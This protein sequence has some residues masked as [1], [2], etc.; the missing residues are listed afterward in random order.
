MPNFTGVEIN[1]P[2]RILIYFMSNYGCIKFCKKYHG[3]NELIEKGFQQLD[4][5]LDM[6]NI[7]T[8]IKTI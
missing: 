3:T 8:R 7:M 2:T 6:K 4:R 5:D 1:G